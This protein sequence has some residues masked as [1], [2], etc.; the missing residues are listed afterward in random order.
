M[1]EP[2]I[3][4]AAERVL[5]QWGLLRLTGPGTLRLTRD[6][7]TV[8]APAGGMLR[9]PYSDLRGGGWRTGTLTV[10]G[11]AGTVA[12]ESG[13]GLD[14]AWVSLIGRVC[15]LPELARSHRLLGSR[16]GGSVDAQARFLAPLLQARRRVEDESDLDARVTTFEAKTLRDRLASAIQAIAKDACPA[17][18]PDRRG[19]EA[20]LEEAMAPLFERLGA[21]E[22]AAE[23]FRSAPESIR[24]AAWRDWVAVVSNVFAL[25]DSGWAS[26]AQLLP[27]PVK[28]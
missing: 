6:A 25:A 23:T 28:P 13:H 22:V 18:S 24:F 5:V 1:P 7:M 8:E 20:E 10:H 11:N 15:P 17:S 9:A 19:L 21:L 2:D 4:V 26:A 27:R 14:L 12:I 16:R 3:E